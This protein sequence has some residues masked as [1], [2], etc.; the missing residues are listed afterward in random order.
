MNKYLEISSIYLQ[1]CKDG[2]FIEG[3]TPLLFLNEYF[4]INLVSQFN[5]TLAGFIMEEC[6]KMPEKGFRLEKDGVIF[7]VESLSKNKI[8]KVFMK[9]TKE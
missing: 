2:Y 5:Q 1:K 4:N 6:G 7:I 9:E 8:E 3:N